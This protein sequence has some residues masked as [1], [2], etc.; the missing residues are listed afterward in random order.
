MKHLKS[1]KLF[2]SNNQTE[3][4]F[5]DKI[6]W[7]LINNLKD[8]S[9]EYLDDGGKL[10]FSA[11]IGKEDLDLMLGTFFTKE[12]PLDPSV[13]M[14]EFETRM[15]K[16]MRD[17]FPKDSITFVDLFPEFLEKAVKSWEKTKKIKY[18][19]C[20]YEPGYFNQHREKDMIA[21]K[22]VLRRITGMYPD[23]K[24]YIVR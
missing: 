7:D 10:L 9:L 4:F 18:G 13:G 5:R 12:E 15:A 24:I 16:R 14:S 11:E 23:E 19:F 21:T 17:Q 20:L 22:E 1:Y 3:N 6:N 8:L 2:E